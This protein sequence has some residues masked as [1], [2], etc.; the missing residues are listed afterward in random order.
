MRTLL[1]VLVILL[2]PATVSLAA[3]PARQPV[4]PDNP[5]RDRGWELGHTRYVSEAAYSGDGKYVASTAYDGS[6]RLWSV[7]TGALLKTLASS[8]EGGGPV[9]FSPD[10]ASLAGTSR[11]HQIG[12]WSVPQGRLRYTHSVPGD[13]SDAFA[14]SPDGT[15]LA[16][17]VS[18]REVLLWHPA[19]GVH[20]TLKVSSSAVDALAF[21][22][23]GKRLMVGGRGYGTAAAM[24]DVRTGQRLRNW[25]TRSRATGVEFAPNGRLMIVSET[26]GRATLRDTANGHVRQ[27]IRAKEP[28][29][30][31]FYFSPR[32]TTLVVASY[33]SSLETATVWDLAHPGRRA[34]TL[35]LDGKE[36]QAV[37]PDGRSFAATDPRQQN[38]VR[39]CDSRTGR[40]RW[41]SADPSL[42]LG[43]K[44]SLALLEQL[45]A[46]YRAYGL[47]SLPPSAYLA[48]VEPRNGLPPGAEDRYLTFVLP[49]ARSDDRT[50]YF[51]GLSDRRIEEEQTVRAVTPEQATLKNTRATPSARPHFPND[52]ITAIQVQERGGTPLALEF[53]KRALKDYRGD[54]RHDFAATAWRYWEQTLVQPDTDRRNALPWMRLLAE[55]EF[56]KRDADKHRLVAD[57]EATLAPGQAPPG[58]IESEIDALVDYYVEGPYA[59]AVGYAARPELSEADPRFRKL[60]LRGFEAVPTLLKHTEDRRLTRTYNRGINTSPPY[61]VR[62]ASVVADLLVGLAAGSEPFGLHWLPE[63]IGPRVDCLKAERWWEQASAIGEEHYL[64]T[65]VL[66][67][68]DS[69]DVAPNAHNAVLIALKYPRYLPEIYQEA[70]DRYPHAQNW[71]LAQLL[72]QSPH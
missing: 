21:S 17:G 20:R 28:Q 8:A 9:Q 50:I 40:E 63:W 13:S 53:L 68:K 34:V 49:P 24:Y 45:R 12:I 51:R 14:W 62:I 32:G 5:R 11:N 27:T 29:S 4:T 42:I 58:S 33:Q 26:D 18:Q 22:P 71:V 66:P 39:L 10:S 72:Q 23:N 38:R 25:L 64:L 69:K 60:W 30:L 61:I 43:S 47:P 65:H 57:L 67:E 3:I 19:T 48:Y 16:S 44:P 54:A 31:R 2:A 59:G 52:V 41:A 15:V 1:F 46:D 37:S 55:T 6:I 36:V 70:L 7:Q 56:L 35:D